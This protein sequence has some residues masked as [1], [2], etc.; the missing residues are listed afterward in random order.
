[1][2]KIN[3]IQKKKSNEQNVIS[4]L[5]DKAHENFKMTGFFQG[6]AS[7]PNL[8]HL[9]KLRPRFFFPT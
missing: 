5:S 9:S 4:L 1:M 7:S 8:H 3:L 6:G 2:K